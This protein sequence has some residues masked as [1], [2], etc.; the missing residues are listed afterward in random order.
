MT[1]AAFRGLS[2]ALAVLLGAGTAL[3]LAA[4]LAQVAAVALHRRRPPRSRARRYPRPRAPGIS[5]LKPLCGADD[6]LADNLAA[7]ATLDYPHYEVVLGVKDAA[8]PACGVAREAVRA[9]PDRFRLVFQRGAPGLNP[10]V[11][12]LITLAAAARHDVL[13]VS[14]SNVRV[15]PG[16]LPE[17]AAHLADDE[18]GLVTHPIVGAGERRLGSYLDHLELICGTAPGVIGAFRIAGH[19]IVVGKSMALRRTD[20]DALGGFA[21]VRDVLA[22]DYVLGRMVRRRLGKRV[23]VA[24]TP[25]VNVGRDRG[26]ADFFARSRRWSIIQRRGVGTPLYVAQVLLNPSF[27]ACLAVP[28]ALAA[29]AAPGRA[30]V[31]AAA[32]CAAHAAIDAAA[33]ALLRPAALTGRHLAALPL[34]NAVRAAAWAAGLI[35]SSVNWRGHRL[36]VQRGTR[37]VP[38]AAGQA[39]TP[40]TVSTSSL[41]L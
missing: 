19:E 13:V 37:L 36:R 33:L 20:L 5:I 9:W 23:E 31:L 15:G 29:G 14:D 7:F 17:V 38:P 8:D 16:Y 10:K 3:G 41:T 2:G 24:R 40:A 39:S 12:Q 32:A 34:K 28:C 1:D 25:V 22:E 35:S 21:S 11:N 18:V 6:D 27:V 26:V 30:L 4:L